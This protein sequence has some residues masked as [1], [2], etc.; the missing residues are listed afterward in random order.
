MVF[1]V[2]SSLVVS[3]VES[4]TSLASGIAVDSSI[5]VV[6]LSVVAEESAVVSP[7]SGFS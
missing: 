5:S 4:V 6:E 3:V 2:A 7:V 1:A